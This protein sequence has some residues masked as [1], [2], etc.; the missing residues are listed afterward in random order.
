[1]LVVMDRR[2]LPLCD[3][4]AH[5]C[6]DERLGP[7]RSAP[8]IVEATQATSPRAWSATTVGLAG[9]VGRGPATGRAIA[10]VGAA[11]LLPSRALTCSLM[12]SGTLFV[13]PSAQ[14]I[15]PGY[16][17]AVPGS[18]QSISYGTG[19]ARGSRP[20]V[21]ASARPARALGRCALSVLLT[22]RRVP[23]PNIMRARRG[24]RAVRP[25]R[26][27][28]LARRGANWPTGRHGGE[29]VCPAPPHPRC[30]PGR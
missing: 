19:E 23:R 15:D 20:A 10:A 24:G 16:P 22:R 7:Y 8:S 13:V 5:D 26:R 29:Q 6:A 4:G 9:D 12:G 1:M 28:C 11:R 14:R 25:C 3:H 30:P 27:P 17:A 18:L 21:V 2:A